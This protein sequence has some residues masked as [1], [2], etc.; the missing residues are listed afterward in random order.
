MKTAFPAA[1]ALFAIIA[2]AA[3]DSSY[4]TCVK[5]S[6]DLAVGCVKP[7][8]AVVPPPPTQAPFREVMERIEREH[9][10]QLMRQYLHEQSDRR[11]AELHHG[12]FL[13]YC[14]PSSPACRAGLL[15]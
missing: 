1:V 14:R 6:G 13:R 12:N 7:A 10:R 15:D 5:L 9:D 3:A 11:A 4:E 8:P 2:P